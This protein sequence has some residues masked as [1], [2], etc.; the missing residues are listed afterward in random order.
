MIAEVPTDRVLPVIGH[1]VGTGRH[2]RAWDHVAVRLSPHDVV[3]STKL[4]EAGVDF[5]RLAIIDHGALDHWQHEDSLDGKADLLFWG[6]DAA[7]AARRSGAPPALEGYGWRDLTVAAATARW[8][9]VER[10]KADHHWL[11]ATDLRPHSHH[12]QALA[13]ARASK[14]G[15]GTITVAG[16]EILLLFT[17][18]GDGVFPIFVDRDASARPVQIRIQ[19]APPAPSGSHA[20]T[21]QGRQ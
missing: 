9:E 20:A 5:A 16:A 21:T 13:K 7:I 1:R 4:G 8:D 17:T 14:H 11:L 18:W 19:L 6:R 2:A 3:A 15:A 10:M 12:Y